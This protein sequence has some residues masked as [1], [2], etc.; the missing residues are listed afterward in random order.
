MKQR[1]ETILTAFGLWLWKNRISDAK[2]A[3]M[4]AKYLGI[5]SFSKRTVEKWRYGKRIPNGINMKAV[6]E[7][8][9]ISA[10]TFFEEPEDANA[11]ND[12]SG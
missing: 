11:E 8:T 1:P 10:D 6:K 7:L 2:F 3:L 5:E 12:R 9:G 4:M